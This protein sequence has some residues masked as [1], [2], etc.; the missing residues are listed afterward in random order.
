MF[1]KYILMLSFLIKH[2][3]C[4]PSFLF[5]SQKNPVNYVLLNSQN[6][7]QSGFDFSK[8]TKF[9]IHGF[10]D[11]GLEEK[12]IKIKDSFIKSGF[13]GNIVSVD[14][15]EGAK[16]PN[17][18][19]AAE[20]VEI[21]GTK[22][23]EFIR[24]V[25]INVSKVH[26]IGHS[27]GAHACGFA[28]KVIKLGRISGLDPA[29]PLFFNRKKERRLNEN[30][31]DFV[32]NIHTDPTFGMHTPIGHLDFFPNGRTQPGC[33]L[34]DR[35]ALESKIISI[36][37]DPSFPEVKMIACSHNKATA[38]FAESIISDCRFHSVP[39][40]DYDG[41]AK[42]RCQCDPK[43]GCA[44]MGYFARKD[45]P[46]GTYYLDTHKHEPYCINQQN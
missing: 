40:D 39:C 35:S 22:L 34:F 6:I 33:G 26:C 37:L 10:T 31:A 25:G 38:Y 32:D 29:G 4:W 14:W 46:E 17:Y 1:S 2:F 11:D 20:N 28:G 5:F 7:K 12:F 18:F 3:A 42:G 44:S 24:E 30:D 41:F 45:F 8:E 9:L 15:E 36:K 43:L 13:D 23:G 27:L 16:A 21:T 19:S